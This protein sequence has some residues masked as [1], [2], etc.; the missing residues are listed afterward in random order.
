MV[1]HP[2]DY[3]WSSYQANAQGEFSELLSHHLLYTALGRGQK[4]K[5]SRLP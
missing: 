1:E 3:P 5:T 4:I 2:A